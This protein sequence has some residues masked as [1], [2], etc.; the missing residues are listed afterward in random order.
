MKPN[1]QFRASR[2]RAPLVRWLIS[3]LLF[4][5]V[6]SATF[7]VVHS[8][9]VVSS[10]HDAHV[11]ASTAGQPIGLSETQF[12]S[13]SQFRRHSNANECLICLLHQQFSSSIVHEHFV[14]T[15]IPPVAFASRIV[16]PRAIPFASRPV[17]RQSGRGPPRV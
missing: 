4:A 1:N 9:G 16:L 14:G 8:H 12:Y 6:Y 11:V 10:E 5:I 7:G 17:T 2:R 3:V 13:H 15:S